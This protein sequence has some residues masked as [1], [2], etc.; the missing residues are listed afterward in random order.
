[1]LPAYA[2]D[3]RVSVVAIHFDGEPVVKPVP[4]AGINVDA[5]SV[6]PS[7]STKN[8]TDGRLDNCWRAAGNEQSSTL[9]LSLAAPTSVQCFSLSEPWSPWRGI[10]QRH[11]LQYWLDGAWKTIVKGETKGAGLL[12]SF[13]PVTAQ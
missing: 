11:E 4:S 10:I 6:D 12:Q 13:M 9:E 3:K 7:T 1:M 5:S 8:I 2:P